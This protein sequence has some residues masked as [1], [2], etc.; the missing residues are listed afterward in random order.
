MS[1]EVGKKLAPLTKPPLTRDHLR[2]YADASED[3]NPIHLDENFAREA[4]FP[5]VIV[6][7]MI[8]MAFLGDLVS[9][10]FPES[11]HRL[12]RFRT[13]FRK[14][15]FP[16]DELTA[17]GEIKSLQPDGGIVVTLKARNQRGE[18]TSDGEAVLYPLETP[19]QA[20][21]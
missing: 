15:T 16:G 13:R 3:R 11:A 18:V 8:S 1:W 6:H 9:H 4:G 14:V 12:Q 2:A 5:S 21:L 19:R 17:E 20:V 7:G 10:H